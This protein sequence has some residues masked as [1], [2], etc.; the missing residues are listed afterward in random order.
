MLPREI[1]TWTDPAV[2]LKITD[3]AADDDK[4][5]VWDEDSIKLL[6]RSTH[7]KPCRQMNV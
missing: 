6:E 2:S 1:V 5:A 4:K 7:W 3:F